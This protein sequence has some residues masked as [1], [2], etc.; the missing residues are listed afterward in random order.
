MIHRSVGRGGQSVIIRLPDETMCALPAWMLDDLICAAVRD[1]THPVVSVSAL[2]RLGSVL[3]CHASL[4]RSASHEPSSNGQHAISGA[5]QPTTALHLR[6]G[7]RRAASRGSKQS[8][9]RTSEGGTDRRRAKGNR[10]AR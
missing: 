10:K 5:A 4:V 7:F 1:E 3:D 2:L 6:D 9:P 8:M